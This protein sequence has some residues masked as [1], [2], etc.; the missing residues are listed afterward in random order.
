MD[1]PDNNTKKGS[2]LLSLVDKRIKAIIAILVIV[3]GFAFFAALIVLNVPDPKR[4]IIVFILGNVTGYISLIL[5]YFFG[6]SEDRHQ[7][8]QKDEKLTDKPA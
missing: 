2:I 5:A 4:E 1:A 8:P 6:S 7:S 3:M